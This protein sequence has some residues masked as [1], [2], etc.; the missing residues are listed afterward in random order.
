MKK[1]YLAVLSLA[2]LAG[3]ATP[4]DPKDV[5]AARACQAFRVLV[6]LVIRMI[7]NGSCLVS[8]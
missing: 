7:P 5:D 6:A 1:G 4:P 3:C 2:I 8:T